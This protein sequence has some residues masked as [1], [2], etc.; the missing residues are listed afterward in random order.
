MTIVS[1]P[2][3]SDDDD[4]DGYDGFEPSHLPGPGP[5]LDGHDV[6]TG[7]DHAAFHRLTRAAF[8]AR[9]V[10]DVT[11][12]YNL[13]RLNLD[14]RHPGAGYR[15]AVDAGDP[16]VLRA[17]F[18]PTTAF[19]PQ[20]DTLVTASFRAWN[21]DD[22]GLSHEFDLVRVR[23]APMHESSAHINRRLV[24]L[25][26]TARESGDVDGATTESDPDRDAAADGPAAPF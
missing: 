10:Y 24:E 15:Y 14:T 6:L 25:E 1:R 3:S 8:E 19:C 11:F 9:R 17:E 5:F 13:A 21:A 2:W 16:S 4:F 26:G 23:V 22:A 12:G 7:A 18:T 20:S